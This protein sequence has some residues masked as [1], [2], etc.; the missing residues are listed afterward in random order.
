MAGG[1]AAGRIA[2]RRQR[3]AGWLVRQVTSTAGAGFHHGLPQNVTRGRHGFAEIV[4]GV[5]NRRAIGVAA[6]AQLAAAQ[7]VRQQPA[8]GRAI[9]QAMAGKA[10][11]RLVRPG[12]RAHVADRLA[13]GVG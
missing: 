12:M 3:F 10:R 4:L 9:M 1:A 7:R 6:E 2:R 11:Q 13:L 8:V 5:D